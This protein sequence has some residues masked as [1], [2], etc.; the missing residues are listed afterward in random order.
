MGLFSAIG[1]AVGSI[2]SNLG[3]GLLGSW[4]QGKQNKKAQ[5]RDQRFQQYMWNQQNEYNLPINQVARLREAGLNPQL[6]LGDVNSVA[7]ASLG[8]QSSSGHSVNAP[9]IDIL[10]AL[11]SYKQ[12]RLLSEKAETER[13]AQEQMRAQTLNTK[14]Q[15]KFL[16]S[17]MRN[18]DAD[19]KLKLLNYQLEDIK[20]Q[21][22]IVGNDILSN[23]SRS[24]YGTGKKA[25]D[26][27]TSYGK[28]LLNNLKIHFNNKVNE[29][30]QSEYY[31]NKNK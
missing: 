20:R 19:T 17:Q 11:E 28:H 31:K 6:A 7:G 4:Y 14:E 23:L 26:G 22:G 2:A 16:G 13:V 5:S 15:I 8:G 9:D 12:I 1:S 29:Y 10:G 3:G 21:S 30:K 27:F 18:L 24:V 25:V